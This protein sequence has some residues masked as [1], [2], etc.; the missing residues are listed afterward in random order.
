[1]QAAQFARSMIAVDGSELRVK[2][3]RVQ[4]LEVLSFLMGNQIEFRT[5]LRPGQTS[6]LV[7]AGKR[8]PV[9]EPYGFSLILC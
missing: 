2:V 8:T 4:V 6:I 7:R 5:H 9:F 1:V 3:P